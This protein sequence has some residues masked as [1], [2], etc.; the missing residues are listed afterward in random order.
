MSAQV[1]D[2]GFVE[3]IICAECYQNI[4]KSPVIRQKILFCSDNCFENYKNVKEKFP[5]GNRLRYTITSENLSLLANNVAK[6]N[7]E[8]HLEGRKRNGE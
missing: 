4:G 7:L 6:K 5:T 8:I 1:K 2:N 3:T